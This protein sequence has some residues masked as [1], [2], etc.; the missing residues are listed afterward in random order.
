MRI[1]RARRRRLI[2][3][4]MMLLLLLLLLQMLLVLL[5]GHLPSFAIVRMMVLTP[6]SSRLT[7][8]HRFH[9]IPS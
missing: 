8:H 4:V 1:V 9:R 5:L 6:L 7:I 2:R 3:H